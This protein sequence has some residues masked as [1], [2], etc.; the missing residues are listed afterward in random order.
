[1]VQL[2]LPHEILVCKCHNLFFHGRILVEKLFA[3]RRDLQRRAVEW[4]VEAKDV[5]VGMRSGVAQL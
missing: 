1:M 4:Q 5:D 3:E 2:V